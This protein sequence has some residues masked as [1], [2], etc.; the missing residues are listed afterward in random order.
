MFSLCI[1][2]PS[3]RRGR[4][5]HRAALYLKSL[6]SEK[7][8]ADVEILDLLNYRFP[9]FEERLK[10]IE[11]PSEEMIGFS[12]KIRN[13]DGVIIIVPE[14]NGGYPASLKNAVD[15]LTDEWRRKPVAFVPVSDG[16]FGGSQAITLFQFSMWKLGTITVYPVLRIPNIVSELD[17]T[18]VP[19][20]KADMD[21]RATGL[22]NGLL[23]YIEAKRRMSE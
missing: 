10:Y 18:G 3:I 12:E 14:Y 8:I 19:E 7:N 20:N 4:N 23:W 15:F 6:I 13:A 2:S 16:S 21:K 17:E 1:I 11:S 5:S 9:L 22:I